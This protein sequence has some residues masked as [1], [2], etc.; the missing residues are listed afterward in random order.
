[1]LR[2][3]I[4]CHLSSS[5][6]AERAT[7]GGF[8]V[9]IGGGYAELA[10]KTM[11]PAWHPRGCRI[12]APAALVRPF[13]SPYRL[14]PIRHRCRLTASI[15]IVTGTSEDAAPLCRRDALID[16]RLCWRGTSTQRW[17][18]ARAAG[19]AR[20]SKSPWPPYPA[21]QPP[22]RLIDPPHWLSV[23]PPSCALR[24][25]RSACAFSQAL[26]QPGGPREWSVPTHACASACV[27]AH[28]R[29]R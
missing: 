23:G 6:P 9:A 27:H 13:S 18:S 20:F 21:C 3:R 28:L 29:W 16:G 22:F 10:L 7:P 1:M 11:N 2:Q 17:S 24:Y 26:A 15:S 19:S 12:P 4:E 8:E 5:K 14:D 25:S